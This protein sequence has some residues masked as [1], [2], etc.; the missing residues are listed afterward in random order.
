MGFTLALGWV[1]SVPYVQAFDT[2][3]ILK[4]SLDFGPFGLTRVS[5]FKK[6]LDFIHKNMR[7]GGDF[8][9]YRIGMYNI[10]VATYHTVH[11]F[12]FMSQV[13]WLIMSDVAH[14]S[15]VAHGPLVIYL[16]ILILLYVYIKLTNHAYCCS[17]EQGGPYASCYL[18]S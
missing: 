11:I 14:V 12:C 2:L 3:L 10:I 7:G 16:S 1:W 9:F 15:D 18:F 17:G 5:E 6:G 8:N 13:S 4:N